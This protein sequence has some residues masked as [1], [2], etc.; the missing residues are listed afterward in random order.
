MKVGSTLEEAG[1]GYRNRLVY[2]KSSS[3]LVKIDGHSD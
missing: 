3:Q 1:W 2:D